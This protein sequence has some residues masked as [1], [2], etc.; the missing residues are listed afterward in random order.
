MAAAGRDRC[1]VPIKPE[2]ID[3]WLKP[4]A[5]NLQR[6]VEILKDRETPY[7]GHRLAA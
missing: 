7:Y 5:D 4:D 6:Q 1:I 2:N 3:A